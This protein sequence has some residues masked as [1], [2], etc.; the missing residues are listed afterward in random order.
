M[1]GSIST[2]VSEVLRMGRIVFEILVS[3]G[4]AITSAWMA[5]LGVHVTSHPPAEAA[6]RGIKR[7]FILCGMI[8]AVLI[9]VQDT[10]AGFAQKELL[11]TTVHRSPI[12]EGADRREPLKQRAGALGE[13]LFNDW[14]SLETAAHTE[15]DLDSSASSLTPAQRAANHQR[16]QEIEQQFAAGLWATKESDLASLIGEIKAEGEGATGISP[17][18]IDYAKNACSLPDPKYFLLAMK[19]CANR[20]QAIAESIH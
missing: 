17:D 2:V 20:L 11:T 18:A 4:L 3:L 1:R 10:R 13:E 9:L 7:K 15:D 19:D 6:R 8:A 16:I 12:V 5:Y 14:N